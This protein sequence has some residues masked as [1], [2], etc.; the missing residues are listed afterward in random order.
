MLFYRNKLGICL[1][2]SLKTL[3]NQNQSSNTYVND[4]VIMIGIKVKFLKKSEKRVKK[5]V[6]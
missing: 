6:T 3:I 4:F 5:A 2:K 1:H